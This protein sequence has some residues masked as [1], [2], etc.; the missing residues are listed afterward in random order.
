MDLVRNPKYPEIILV[1]AV[2]A[3]EPYKVHVTFTDGSERTI[4]LDPYLRGPMF[5]PIRNDARV[6]ASVFVD[7]EGHTLAWPNG[8]DIA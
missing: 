6:F 7:P 5:R 4:D 3:L 2:K 1:R 8:A